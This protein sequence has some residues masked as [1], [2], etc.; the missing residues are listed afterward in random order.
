MGIVMH[1][2]QS[3]GGLRVSCTGAVQASIDK[4][5][6]QVDGHLAGSG[7]EQQCKMGSLTLRFGRLIV[8]AVLSQ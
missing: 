7:S 5:A 2:V 3:A 4:S 8:V 1:D 6:V